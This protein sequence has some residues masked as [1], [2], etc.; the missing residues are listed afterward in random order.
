[1]IYLVRSEAYFEIAHMRNPRFL[2]KC[3]SKR[4]LAVIRGSFQGEIACCIFHNRIGGCQIESSIRQRNI[5]IQSSS[6]VTKR[7]GDAWVLGEQRFV[8]RVVEE[9]KF[10]FVVIGKVKCF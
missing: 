9:V 7:E 1:M 3:P 2:Q 4:I 5:H 8:L 10:G 6:Q